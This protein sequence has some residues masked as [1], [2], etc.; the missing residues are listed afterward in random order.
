MRCVP[1]GNRYRPNVD[2]VTMFDRGAKSIGAGNLF[3]P[4]ISHSY[5][6]NAKNTYASNTILPNGN[7]ILVEQLMEQLTSQF[8][9]SNIPLNYT[10]YIGI[11][12]NSIF[13]LRI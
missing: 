11:P 1:Q 7:Q 2:P 13:L 6:G 8:F 4:G 10:M 12:F 3:N 5:T 9:V